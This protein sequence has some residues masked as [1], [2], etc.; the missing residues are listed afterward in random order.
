MTCGHYAGSMT[1][2]VAN[3]RE[4]MDVL[5]HSTPGTSLKYQ[6]SVSG[7]AVEIAAD[8]SRLAEVPVEG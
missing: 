6:H 7:R 4:V 5:G 8:L 1:A 3:V 2:R